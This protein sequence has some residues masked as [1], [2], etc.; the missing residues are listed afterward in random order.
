M[1]W[2]NK[3]KKNNV[4]SP[5]TNNNQRWEELP[6][7]AIT[8]SDLPRTWNDDGEAIDESIEAKL[9]KDSE[10]KYLEIVTSIVNISCGQLA[11][12]NK[13]KRKNRKILLIFFV[14]FLAT[15]YV[16]MLGLFVLK[17]FNIWGFDLKD[18]IILTYITSVFVETLGAI[19]IMVTYAF[20]SDQEVQ[21]LKILNGVV[22]KF[23]KFS[24]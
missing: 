7:G 3:T 10:G 19:I 6:Q 8:V 20:Q 22:E 2:W 4:K 17:G 1:T 9:T 16:V 5:E 12:Q 18:S 23:Q 13:S 24:K 14:V 11:D 21:I 15:Q